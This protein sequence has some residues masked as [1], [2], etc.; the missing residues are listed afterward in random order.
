MLFAKHVVWLGQTEKTM[1][2]VSQTYRVA[3][4]PR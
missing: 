3:T 1:L 4:R 2:P